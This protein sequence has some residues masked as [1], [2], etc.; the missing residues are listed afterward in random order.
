[1]GENM[2]AISNTTHT[3]LKLYFHICIPICSDATYQQGGRKEGNDK[4]GTRDQHCR[5]LLSYKDARAL[6]QRIK[7]RRMKMSTIPE[8]KALRRRECSIVQHSTVCVQYFKKS[9]VCGS[10]FFARKP[11]V[12]SRLAHT[13]THECK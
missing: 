3:N 4:V 2:G 8:R 10:T 11:K 6:V 5:I 12:H 1:M 7:I 13:H 9:S